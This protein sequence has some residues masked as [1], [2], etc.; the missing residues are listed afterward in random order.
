MAV[1]WLFIR[2]VILQVA[3]SLHRWIITHPNGQTTNLFGNSITFIAPTAGTYE[4]CHIAEIRGLFDQVICSETRC[5]RVEA[6]CGPSDCVNPCDI[7]PVIKSDTKDGCTYTFK[8]GN[9]GTECP[10][11]MYQWTVFN[12][13]GSLVYTF[14]GENLIDYTFPSTG[15]FKVCLK[16]FVEDED[17][18][19]RCE[20]ER[21]IK[22]ETDCKRCKDEC[23][24]DPEIKEDTDDNCHL[25]FLR[26]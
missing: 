10:S 11:Q 8:G 14:N 5:N 7:K 13:F 16:I 4:V 18:N 21:C 23:K 3:T 24:I 6:T 25:R 15:S 19:I 20:R 22:V 9:N 17:G 12:G 26:D 1:I 2:R